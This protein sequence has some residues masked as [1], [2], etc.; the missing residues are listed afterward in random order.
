VSAAVL[1]DRLTVLG[2][3]L[4]DANPPVGGGPARYWTVGEGSRALRVGFIA[5]LSEH[6]CATCNR[7]R[8]LADG[9][10]RTCLAHEETPSLRDLLR[11]GATDDDLAAAVRGIV[12]GKPAGHE[13]HLPGGA[14][15]E[16]VMTGIGG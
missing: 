12:L 14:A 11:S 8:L 1:R 16:G 9:H 6:F 13:A 15:F 2:P 10:L 4:P 5:P 7:L 3:V